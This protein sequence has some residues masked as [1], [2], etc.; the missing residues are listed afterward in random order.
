MTLRQVMAEQPFDLFSDLHEDHEATGFYMYEAERERRRLGAQ[1]VD[2]VKQIGSI[3]SEDNTDP[4]LEMPVSEGLFEINPAWRTSGW[5]AY[6]YFES[7]THGVLT[8]TPSTAWPLH[9]R[10]E[11]HLLALGLVLDYYQ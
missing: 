10:V 8:E 1:I 11:A 9:T 5:S 6:A 7:A 4:G 3:D 2:V